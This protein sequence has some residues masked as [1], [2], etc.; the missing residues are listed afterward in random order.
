MAAIIT[1]EI[2]PTE[3]NTVEPMVRVPEGII[4]RMPVKHDEF[5]AK[6]VLPLIEYL[7]IDPLAQKGREERLRFT[8]REKEYLIRFP[9]MHI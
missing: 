3:L 9:T 7:Q 1:K 5:T 6:Y 4:K 2:E 8:E